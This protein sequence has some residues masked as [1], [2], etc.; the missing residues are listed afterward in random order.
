ME[1][2]PESTLKIIRKL[3]KTYECKFHRLDEE[4]I[5]VLAVT[6][7][8]KKYP[9]YDPERS[10]LSTYT[11]TTVRNHLNNLIKKQYRQKRYAGNYVTYEDVDHMVSY[12]ENKMVTN[13]MTYEETLELIEKNL[14]ESEWNILLDILDDTHWS[15]IR[16]KYGFTSKN[17]YY[18][19]KGLIMK[20][21]R[22]IVNGAR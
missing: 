9:E 16:E 4:D 3:S 17:K 19:K 22:N 8:I 6:Y 13:G 5:Y 14:P 15:V 20:K 10:R 18:E 21:C 7:F 1:Y 12:E 11:Y 2:L